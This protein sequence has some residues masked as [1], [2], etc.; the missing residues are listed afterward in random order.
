MRILRW[1]MWAGLA[2]ALLRPSATAAAQAPVETA[3]SRPA[4]ADV[5]F[6]QGMIAHHAQAVTMAALVPSR[7]ARQEMRLLAQRIDVSQKD[8]IAMMQG[9]L[10]ERGFPVPIE[11]GDH[12]HHDAAGQPLQ[13]PGMLTA[14]EMARLADATGVA[15]ERLFLEGMIRHHQGALTMVKQLFSAGGA[16][17]AVIF[18]FASDVDTDQRAEIARMSALLSTLP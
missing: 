3:P 12:Q 15:F 10:R 18:R 5:R 16:Q 14:D 6:M 11:G 13:M 4:E 1:T 17:E 7:T 9:W 8:E 2:G